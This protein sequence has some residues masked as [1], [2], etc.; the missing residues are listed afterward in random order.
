MYMEGTILGF[1]F[2]PRMSFLAQE[3][4]KNHKSYRRSENSDISI[5]M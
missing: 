1:S 3:L 5:F 4:D 2:N